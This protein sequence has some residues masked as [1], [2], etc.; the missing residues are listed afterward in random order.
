MGKDKRHPADKNI[1]ILKE[2]DVEGI[3]G[4]WK[5]EE[6]AARGIKAALERDNVVEVV[7]EDGSRLVTV[8]HTSTGGGTA[9]IDE[10]EAAC[11]VLDEGNQNHERSNWVEAEDYPWSMEDELGFFGAHPE[12]GIG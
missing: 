5:T 9:E 7:W 2:W 8:K 11:A 3:K 10:R 1:S 6:E 4:Q 12:W